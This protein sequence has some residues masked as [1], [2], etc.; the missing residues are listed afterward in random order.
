MKTEVISVFVGALG[1]VKK[2]VVQNIKKVSGRATVT[3]IQKIWDL[4]ESSGRCLV[5]EHN[6]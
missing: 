3:E 6:D 4:C 1:T 5:Y 2:G